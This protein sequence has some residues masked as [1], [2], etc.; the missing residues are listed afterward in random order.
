LC[1]GSA[2]SIPG[3]DV[4]DAMASTKDGFLK[5]GGHSF[6]GGFS[7]QESE[8]ARL[9]QNL[10]QF[11]ETHREEFPDSWQSRIAYDCELPLD[12]A[13]L[14]LVG[15]LNSLKPFGNQFEEPRFCIEAEILQVTYYK[16]KETGKPK[17]TAV[18]VR[19]DRGQSQKL[20]FFNEVHDELNDASRAKFV[21]SASR[22]TFRGVS[23]LSLTGHDF[24]V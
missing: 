14:E 7:F 10:I 4:T 16:D 17:H 6:A 11:A 2:R 9:R 21:V 5:F 1:K 12:L 15:H 22:N 20:M 3:F 19:L 24:T 13:S 8:E 18:T 23:S